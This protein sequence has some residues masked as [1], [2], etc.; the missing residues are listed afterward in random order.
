MDEQRLASAQ[1]QFCRPPSRPDEQ[2]SH[3]VFQCANRYHC[4]TRTCILSLALMH[5]WARHV[6]VDS[7]SQRVLHKESDR[8]LSAS[9]TV[10]PIGNIILCTIL[11]LIRRYLRRNTKNRGGVQ[12]GG[13]GGGGVG[14]GLAEVD[15]SS[16]L[17]SSIRARDLGGDITQSGH[18]LYERC[19]SLIEP[20][21]PCFGRRRA[22][23]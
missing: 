15:G 14:E 18:G 7:N 3:S 16:S 21:P 5:R 23:L 22:G 11:P 17:H 4:K 13:R 8:V 6:K 19:W 12:R 20:L 2:R 9:L 1:R 10:L